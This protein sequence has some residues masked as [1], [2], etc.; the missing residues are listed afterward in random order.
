MAD[1]VVISPA[2]Y[3]LVTG[4]FD[5]ED[6]GSGRSKAF[7]RSSQCIESCERAKRA[8]ASKSRSRPG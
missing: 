5:R 8:A 3:R 6:M 7:P 4:F 2:T 1:S